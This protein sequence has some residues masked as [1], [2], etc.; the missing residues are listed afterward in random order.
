MVGGHFIGQQQGTIT[1]PTALYPPTESHAR[2]DREGL[3]IPTTVTQPVGPFD[4]TQ[5]AALP[6]PVAGYRN[7][8]TYSAAAS[9]SSCSWLLFV[10]GDVIV[11]VFWVL[12]FSFDS[13][14]AC[15]CGSCCCCLEV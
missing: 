8:N 2:R 10:L 6:S 12:G 1:S 11:V 5:E 13:Y 14:F 15:I 7:R 4:P 3:T 9:S